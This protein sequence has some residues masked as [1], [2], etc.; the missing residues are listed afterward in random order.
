MF[1]DPCEMENYDCWESE[2]PAEHPSF[3]KINLCSNSMKFW[4][5]EK[6]W[7]PIEKSMKLHSAL[8]VY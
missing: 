1:G 6:N 4:K 5:W 2:L 3:S 7:Q 8:T